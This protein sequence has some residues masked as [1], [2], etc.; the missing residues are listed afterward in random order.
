M[1]ANKI[2]NWGIVAHVDAGKTTL[3]EQLL[4]QSGT[5]RGI[6]RVDDG[7]TVTDNMALEKERGI[8]IRSTTVS[9]NYQG[10]TINL[11]DTPGHVDFVAEV[12]RSLSVLDGAILAISAREG[13]QVQTRVIFNAL[14]R[15]KIPTL[16]VINKVDRMG[17][18]M[19]SIYTDIKRDLTDALY[20]VNHVVDAGSREATLQPFES[21]P[22]ILAANCDGVAMQDLDFLEAYCQNNESTQNIRTMLSCAAQALFNQSTLFPVLHA[23]ALHGLGIKAVLEAM[24]TWLEMPQIACEGDLSARVYK[25]NHLA[26]G[27]RLCYTRIFKGN[28]MLRK[29]Y[30]LNQETEML[31]VSNLF[32]LDGAKLV[33]CH[34]ANA[35]E[36]VVLM[37]RHLRVETII[38]AP[39]A[40]LPMLSIA[41][42]TLKATVK[43]SDLGQR[44]AICEAL[45]ILTDE[46][47]FLDYAIHPVTELIEIKLFGTVQ[48]EIIE[49]L[50]RTRFDIDTVIEPPKTIYKE[51]PIASSAA[52]I[53][54]YKDGNHLPATVGIEIEPLPEG[55][56]FMYTSQVS[57]GDLMKSFQNAVEEGIAIG[58]RQG[59]KGWAVT[60]IH[61]KFVF[62]EYNSV[63]STPADFRKLAPEV[64]K[65]ALTL[66]DTECL[67]PIMA[68][69]LMVPQYAIGRAISDVLRMRGRIGEPTLEGDMM[70]LSGYL[71]LETSKDY[72]TELNDYTE[73]KGMIRTT[74]YRYERYIE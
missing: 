32:K 41:T 8:T 2:L 50:L 53:Y 63:D 9:F 24:I 6:G 42:P 72:L 43:A 13:V 61:V 71:P 3:T 35:G 17:V 40:H 74:F 57:L 30:P 34:E 69:D 55:S 66:S 39:P 28:L 12:E 54:M 4:Y 16:I 27:H 26:N 1:N 29:A 23:S 46:D 59:L 33:A 38:G 52:C 5:I 56:G 68:F 36:V 37:D 18:C 22:A 62:S 10:N 20:L 49:A 15:L 45:D 58:L 51:R 21:N 25:I 44:R 64:L 47:P 67:E 7:N 73:G 70:C 14:R 60:D 31:K 65:Q 48:S 19:D 11:L